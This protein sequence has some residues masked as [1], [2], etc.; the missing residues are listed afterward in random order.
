MNR[1]TTIIR[2]EHRRLAAVIHCLTGVLDDIEQRGLEPDFELFESVLEYLESF[3][4]RYHHP[5]EDSHLFPALRRRSP[6]AEAVLEKLEA[7]HARGPKLLGRLRET[8]QR[9][10][11]QGPDG[12]AAFRDAVR[13][14]HDFEWQHM[15]TEEREVLPLAERTLTPEDW[16]ALDA[17]FTSH[18]DPVFGDE[19]RAAFGRLLS[20]IVAHAPSPHGLGEPHPSGRRRS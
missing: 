19:P 8:L 9:Y 20:S 10:R 12:Y 3:L 2:N 11:E 16:A 5:K 7:E 14:Y 18:D 6:E 1:T 13:E 4:Y 15:G 17:T